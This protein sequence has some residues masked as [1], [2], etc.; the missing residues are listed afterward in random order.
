MYF[1]HILTNIPYT[2]YKDVHQSHVGTPRPESATYCPPTAKWSS[3]F[4]ARYLETTNEFYIRNSWNLFLSLERIYSVRLIL[5]SNNELEFC[6][7][8]FMTCTFINI[9]ADSRCALRYQYSMYWFFLMCCIEQL[10]Y[11]STCTSENI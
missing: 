11:I 4:H 2:P 6:I 8:M 5:Y 1:A 10:L 9:D 3:Q 7:N